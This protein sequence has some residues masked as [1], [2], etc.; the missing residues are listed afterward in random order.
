M[1]PTRPAGTEF[2]SLARSGPVSATA[3]VLVR[4]DTGHEIDPV[5]PESLRPFLLERSDGSAGGVELH[6]VDVSFDDGGRLSGFARVEP[7]PDGRW[8]V[9]IREDRDNEPHVVTGGA[10][11]TDAVYDL[12]RSW[13]AGDGWWQEAFSWDP[14]APAA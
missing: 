5:A 14:S 8:L 4:D 10:P 7:Q 1:I 13:T 3:H 9:R 6:T 2:P 11:N 12:L